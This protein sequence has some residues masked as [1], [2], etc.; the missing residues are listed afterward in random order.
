MTCGRCAAP[1]AEYFSNDGVPLCRVC[2]FAD[3]TKAQEERALDSI[4]SETGVRLDWKTAQA[5]AMT[6]ASPGRFIV[7][8]FATIV[9]ALAGGALEWV[10]LGGLHPLLWG[11][12]LLAGVASLGRG[13]Q[14]RR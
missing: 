9:A 12:V 13:L 14:L 3:Q 6:D 7:V 5:T 8:G 2:Y 4:E 1:S 11:V 10:L